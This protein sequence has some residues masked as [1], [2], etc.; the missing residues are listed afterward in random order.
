MNL[1]CFSFPTGFHAFAGLQPEQSAA[2]TQKRGPTS[3]AEMN[4]Q[5]A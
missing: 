2:A 1:C 5:V 4:D 3:T